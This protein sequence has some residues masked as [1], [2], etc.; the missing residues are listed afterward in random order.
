MG[1]RG[2]GSARKKAPDTAAKPRGLE[3]AAWEK[4]GLTLAE[5][6]ILF[7]E[8]LPCTKGFGAGENIRLLPFQRDWIT[9]ICA[10]GSD[11]LRIV[12]TAVLSAGRGNGK[13]VLIAGLCLAAL[14]GPLAEPRAEVYSAAATR[15]QAALIFNEIEAWI[16]RVRWLNE[17]LNVQ[18]FAKKIEDLESGS[19]YKALASDGPAAHGLAAS[20]IACDELAQ[21]KRRELYDVLVT[22]QGKRKQPLMC[23][24]S[25][26][27]PNPSNVLSELL[28]YGERVNS[29]EIE[30]RTF[31]SRLFAVPETASPWDESVWPLA[32]P[33]LGIIRSLEEMQQEARRAQRM[34]TFEA[35]F[36]NLYLNQRVDAEPKAILPIEWEAAGGKVD[37][38]A[39]KGRP[40]FAGL[41]LS[42]T[43]DM[44]AAVLYFP[45]D[46]GAVLAHFWLPRDGLA[47]KEAVDRAP[48]RTWVDAGFLT[49]TPGAAINKR[50]IVAHLAH[51]AA[52]YRLQGIA[53]DR[54]GMPEIERIMAEEGVTLPLKEHG[55]GHK[56][57]GPSTSAFEAAML[58][59]RLNHGGNPILRWQ[60]ANLVY[61]TDPAGNRKPAKNRAIDRIDG[62][63][64][65]IMAIGSSTRATPKRA[66][67]YA[68]RGLL[69]VAAS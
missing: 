34:P 17:R 20:F 21:W 26:Q 51:L 69:T 36:R 43:R 4:P 27:S 62:M 10:E 57:M 45:N 18:R 39:L 22:S 52:E 9:A 50:F 40:C 47:E 60:S 7:I 44:S 8:S 23:I 58:D 28:D 55:Q 31:H 32:N 30:D 41:D 61:E 15:D 53:F 29:G 19:I 67:V 12:R 1:L 5:R 48:Y 35:P 46:D 42:A 3:E 63:V 14:V 56:D 33:G 65:L 49:L 16:V 38:E 54:W 59:G 64:A 37:A 6:V 66:S 2:P 25:T 68:T 24:I 13:T 11:G